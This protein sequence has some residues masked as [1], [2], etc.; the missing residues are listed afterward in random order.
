MFS[1]TLKRLAL[2]TCVLLECLIL[3]SSTI[4]ISQP[5]E[6][7]TWRP[8]NTYAIKVQDDYTDKAVQCWQVDLIV[9]GAECEGI[10]VH[11]GVVAEISKCYNTQSIL[12]FKVPTDL[13]HHGKGFQVQFSSAGSPPIYNSQIFTITNAP[14]K[15]SYEA[16]EVAFEGF[17]E[18]Q[19]LQRRDVSPEIEARKS[20]N[21]APFVLPTV[22]AT[23]MVLGFSCVFAFFMI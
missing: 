17:E 13:V 15:R 11:D 9:L 4:I 21:A 2:I 1:L 5:H 6:D 19:Q 10:C 23:T 16:P 7:S 18:D 12:Q 3:V 22:L 14:R 8:G 20:E